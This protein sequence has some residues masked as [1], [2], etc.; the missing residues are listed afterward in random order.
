MSS[1]QSGVQS[2]NEHLQDSKSNAVVDYTEGSYH[3]PV[4]DVHKEKQKCNEKTKETSRIQERNNTEMPQ[5]TSFIQDA[6]VDHGFIH[7]VIK[8]ET[9]LEK[10]LELHSRATLSDYISRYIAQT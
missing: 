1:H 9:E 3:F 7:G 8:N 10:L 6:H 4:T 2:Q 5:W